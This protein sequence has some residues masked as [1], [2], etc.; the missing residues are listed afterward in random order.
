MCSLNPYWTIEFLK[1]ER[2]V[3]IIDANTMEIETTPKELVFEI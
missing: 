2:K 1:E 3:I